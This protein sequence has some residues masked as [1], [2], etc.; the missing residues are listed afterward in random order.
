[1]T[2]ISGRAGIF[3]PVI[4]PTGLEFS[5]RAGIFVRA[6]I[7]A[8]AK[9]SA[10]AEVHHVIGPSVLLVLFEHTNVTAVLN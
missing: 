5:A 4:A 2:N 10:R 8:R 3:S 7:L 9:L 1:M 6:G